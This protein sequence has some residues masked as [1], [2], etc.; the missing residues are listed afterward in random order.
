MNKYGKTKTSVD[1]VLAGCGLFLLLIYL[2]VINFFN[3]SNASATIADNLKFW[4]PILET[5]IG[6]LFL[7]A[8]V[9]AFIISV[10]EGDPLRVIVVGYIICVISFLEAILAQFFLS[11]MVADAMLSSAS[12]MA[13]IGVNTLAMSLNLSGEAF[14]L[15]LDAAFSAFMAA[16]VG[17]GW[18]FSFIF[19]IFKK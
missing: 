3:N 11:L 1:Y 4:G 18:A 12:I 15:A 17:L 7:G 2:S 13:Q 9:I 6:I 10:R 19:S 14:W 8:L 5:I 16:L